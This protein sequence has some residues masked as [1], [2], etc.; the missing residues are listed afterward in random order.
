MSG[1][2]FY[3][4]DVTIVQQYVGMTTY[5]LGFCLRLVEKG[6]HHGQNG[7][8][9]LHT[10]ACCA[11]LSGDHIYPNGI[12]YLIVALLL[13]KHSLTFDRCICIGMI[14]KSFFT[15]EVAMIKTLLMLIF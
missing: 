11:I 3:E 4:S 6:T 2:N 14:T 8:Y 1:S 10:A 12:F 13:Q 7:Q 15:R 5:V 9:P